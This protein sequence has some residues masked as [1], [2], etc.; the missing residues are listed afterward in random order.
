MEPAESLVAAWDFAGAAEAMR[1]I[2]FD[3]KKHAARLASRREEI[4]RLAALKDR[5]IAK[6]NAANPPQKVLLRGTN[7]PIE[8]ADPSG[9]TAKLPNGKTELLPWSGLA[10]NTRG[11]LCQLTVADQSPDDRIAAGLLALACRDAASAE[12]Y[13]KQAG[14]LRADLELLA[15]MAF[16]AAMRRL[17]KEEN[18]EALTALTAM[19][20]KYATTSWFKEN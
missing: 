16:A 8:K 5:M 4:K 6:I 2:E 18:G 9:I 15:P 1:K 13:I 19:A 17:E 12:K 3:D 10:G 14:S 7:V 11:K 20:E